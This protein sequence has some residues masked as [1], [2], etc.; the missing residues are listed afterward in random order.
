MLIQQHKLRIYVGFDWKLMQQ[1]RTKTVDSGD[2]RP[3]K[4]AFMAQP[5][6]SFIAAGGPQ[7]L[8][9]FF[10]EAA[11]HLVGSAIGKSDGDDLIYGDVVGAENVQ[12]TLD[13]DGGLARARPSR[14]GNM[15]VKHLCSLSLFRSQ[16]K[17]FGFHELIE[18]STAQTS[19]PLYLKSG[20]LSGKI[21]FPYVI[22][23]FS[24][25]LHP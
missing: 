11:A 3:I 18:S 13:Q 6:A 19:R 20:Q 2:Y 12:V 15:P 21:D 4:R 24:L 10:P 1:P 9:Q 16:L 25:I 7:Q 23:H 8:I 14:Y 22:S 17:G 5:L